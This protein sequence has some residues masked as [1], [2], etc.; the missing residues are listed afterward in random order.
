MHYV[1]AL[2]QNSRI[3]K[4]AQLMLQGEMHANR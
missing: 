2:G 3:A 4:F 1:L